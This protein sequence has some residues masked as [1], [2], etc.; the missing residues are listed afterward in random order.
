MVISQRTVRHMGKEG[1][2]CACDSFEGFVLIARGCTLHH[3][4]YVLM[5]QPSTR[6][7][8]LHTTHPSPTGG[9]GQKVRVIS[10][11]SFADQHTMVLLNLRTLQCHPIHFK[12]DAGNDA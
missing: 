12:I 2:V 7:S 11:P 5:A 10:V 4:V 6:A 8:H 1:L 9:Q 3:S